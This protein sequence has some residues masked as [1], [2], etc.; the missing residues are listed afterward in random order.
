MAF[1]LYYIQLDNVLK[2]YS[3]VYRKIYYVCLHLIPMPL[4][5][6]NTKCDILIQA[7]AIHDKI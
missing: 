4:L 5:T 1:S 3:V 7:V 6:N 2:L